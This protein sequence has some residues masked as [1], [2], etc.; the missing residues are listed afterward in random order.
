ME[1][2]LG[3]LLMPFVAFAGV[4]ALLSVSAVGF[5]L[6]YA[7][8]VLPRLIWRHFR[9]VWRLSEDRPPDDAAV[10]GR[11]P[12]RGPYLHRAGPRVFRALW[13]DAREAYAREATSAL[14]RDYELFVVKDRPR[15]R[16]EVIGDQCFGLLGC[17]YRGCWTLAVIS[18]TAV[19]FGA[20]LLLHLLVWAA[21]MAGFR[22]FCAA[23]RVADRAGHRLTGTATVCPHSG[24]GRFVALPVRLC[25]GCGAQHRRLEPD[26]NGALHRICRCGTRLPAAI[27]S[28]ARRLDARCPHCSRPMLRGE[29]RTRLVLIAGPSGSGRSVLVRSG[30]AQ[31]AR[32]VRSLG[33]S[34]GGG[35]PGA[36]AT[37]LF[38]LRGGSR[39]LVLLDPPGPAF[40][41]Q[42]EL[43]TLDALRHAHGLV[44]V[45]DGPALTAVR[46]ASTTEDRERISSVPRAAQDPVDTAER[47]L[48]NVAS[49]PAGRR[50][51]RIAVVLTKTAALRRTSAGAGLADGD[52]AIRQW[53]VTA[54]AGNLVR[55]VED[56]AVPV[57]FLADEAGADGETDLG[58]L[59]LWTAGVPAA[60][61]RRR[62]IPPLRVPRPVRGHRPAAARTGRARYTLLLSHFAGFVALPLMLVLLQTAAL[63]STA[64]FGL[65]GAYDRWADPLPGFTHDRDLT[66][67]HRGVPWPRFKASY[68]AYGT[69]PAGPRT[70][71][72]G[73]WST[74]GSPSSGERDASDWLEVDFGFPVYISR[75]ELALAGAAPQELEIR[76][77][78]AA[79][80]WTARTVEHDVTSI[81]AEVNQDEI[82]VGVTTSAIRIV[83]PGINEPGG[84]DVGTLRVWSPSSRLL[85]LRPSG[86]G[87]LLTSTVNRAVSVEV[88]PPVLPPGWR[89]ASTGAPP[90]RVPAGATVSAGLRLTAGADAQSGPARYAVRIT[91]DGHTATA[92]C[93]AWLTKA[94]SGPRVQPVVCDSG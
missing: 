17:A 84:V 76:T 92:V 81:G 35:V 21:L 56:S 75:V 19:L 2:A 54:G 74:V 40:A 86:S 10:T 63:P 42:S 80:G 57:R 41:A 90:R 6:Y 25:P 37:G 27:A 58:G 68:S 15:R 1:F 93:V 73:F 14:T 16:I 34:A 71:I 22:L 72:F 31:L 49:L 3:V 28:G 39:S 59:L 94:A 5:A 82:A 70:G 88:R 64:L 85:R 83:V 20:A 62:V 46:R 32:R 60:P 50:P 69:T 30:L 89:A 79:G 9:A 38:G 44:L 7:C 67:Y 23:L 13:Q 12:V 51:R 43:D 45:L 77:P 53:L 91:E 33:G 66:E 47:V 36:A 18:A 65:P 24:C 8:A 52:D 11:E 61:R 55:V 87:L 78:N 29:R 4:I 26:R 48:R